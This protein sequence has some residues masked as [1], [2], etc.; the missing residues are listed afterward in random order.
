MSSAES[1][2]TPDRDR[3]GK[4]VL[5]LGGTG[6]V[7]RAV[8]AGL[9]A[10]GIRAAFSYHRSGDVAKKLSAATGF[11]A[12]PLDCSDPAGIAALFDRLD[13]RRDDALG[14]P[15]VLVHCATAAPATDMFAIAPEEWDRIHAVNVR[16]AFL[17]ARELC[18]RREARPAAGPVGGD[19]VFTAAISGT[20]AVPA[21][22]HFA[23]TQAALAGL[24]RTLARRLGRQGY[25][26][27][28]ALFGLLD[29]G[30]SQN[31]SADLSAAYRRFSAF[32][33]IGSAAEAARTVL[34]LALDNT[35]MT[36]A[37]LSSTGGL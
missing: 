13:E 37:T 11:C 6:H 26:V 32:R 9:A 14:L 29:G 16:S 24:T 4:T 10:R 1:V 21:P 15:D 7:G 25:R 12:Y 35:Y 27:N 34:W 3:A 28:L 23:T 36:G 33:R 31:L 20:S 30:I 18:R 2:A 22:V 5:V 17:A 19:I 8:V